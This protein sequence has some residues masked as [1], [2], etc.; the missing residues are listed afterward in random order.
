MQNAL[1]NFS[2]DKQTADKSYFKVI[3]T[4]AHQILKVP[5]LPFK[6]HPSMLT[7]INYSTK[8]ENINLSPPFPT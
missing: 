2:F 5:Q 4:S 3:A 7:N 6:T 8:I 1:V